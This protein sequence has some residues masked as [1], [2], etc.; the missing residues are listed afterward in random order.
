MACRAYITTFISASYE[1]MATRRTNA[2][3][4][5]IPLSRSLISVDTRPAFVKSRP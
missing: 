1:A 4:M 2:E 5:P 3:S